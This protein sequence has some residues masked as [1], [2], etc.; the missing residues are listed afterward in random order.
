MDA[1]KLN[2]K[3]FAAAASWLEGYDDGGAAP[4]AGADAHA[5]LSSRAGLGS[6]PARPRGQAET[7]LAARLERDRR[8]KRGDDADDAAADAARRG[9]SDSSS[10]DEAESRYARGRKRAADDAPRAPAAPPPAKRKKKQKKKKQQ[11]AG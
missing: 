10:D 2:P 4:D 9:G 1:V 6:A 3:A 11:P 8:R 5:P 7:S